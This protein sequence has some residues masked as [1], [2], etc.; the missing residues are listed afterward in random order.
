MRR[1]LFLGFTL[2]TSAFLLTNCA[3][4]EWEPQPSDSTSS[5]N[6]TVPPGTEKNVPFEV[7]AHVAATK[8]ASD[9]EN[10]AWSASDAVN[11][12]YAVSG[13]TE[14]KDTGSAE[15]DK[16]DTFKGTLATGIKDGYSYDWFLFY[17]YTEGL[18]VSGN[19][20][21]IT[22]GAPAGNTQTQAGYGSRAHIGGD[23]LPM[24]GYA[25]G[26][27]SDDIPS[28]QMQHLASVV[29][30]DVS[31]GATPPLTVTEIILT[32]S[33][34]II[35]TYVVD[36][37]S[38]KPEYKAVSG[39]KSA[40]LT[41][42]D[43][44]ELAKHETASFYIVVKPFT[45]IPSSEIRISV[46]GY[47]KKVN[48]SET[49]EFKAGESGTL[50]FVYDDI[51]FKES[52][53]GSYSIAGLW[54][55]GGTGLDY[56]GGGFV[57]MHNKEKLFD[58][59]GG[60]GV[61]AEMDNYLEFTFIDLIDEGRKTT[62]KCYNW[63]GEDGKN[64]SC[65]YKQSEVPWNQADLTHFYRQIP[66]GES[67]WTRD[68]SVEPNTVTFT[69]SE[70]KETVLELLAPQTANGHAFENQT[71]HTALNGTD[72]W[73][74]IYNDID[75][76]YYK[77]RD[78]YI[79]II[80]V[81]SVPEASRTEEGPFVPTLPPDPSVVPE[82]IAGTYSYS[83]A[84]CFGGMDPAFV[85]FTEKSWAFNDSVWNM[86]DDVYV[87]TA[88]GTDADGN[89]TG[90][91]D[92]QPGEGGTYWDLTYPADKHNKDGLGDLDLSPFYGKIAQ[93]K[94]QYIYNKTDCTVTF[95]SGDRTETANFLVPGSHDFSGKSHEVI[96]TFALDFNLN[97]TEPN[98]PGY[99]QD[100]SDFERFYVAPQNFVLH[101]Q[102]AE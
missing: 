68:Y 52:L 89:E 19:S 82:S 26:V 31:N 8:T 51:D 2:A 73:N 17:P 4:Q 97:Y 74:A 50:E 80:K 67:T 91:V 69:D 24:Y 64:W 77:P 34:D 37:S 76:V 28:A 32:A 22:I 93:G 41:V 71:F 35:G 21:E 96:A 83:N 94:S 49:V 30:I 62:G 27:P 72:N 33:E 57:D 10:L 85:G 78:Y 53:M 39:G 47:E 25:M 48:L 81:E 29:R 46:N 54:V 60:H 87:F 44:K 36:F 38:S 70:G 98:I 43:G 75:K 1:I 88:T 65:W 14:F 92:F 5:D 55:Y 12:W 56:G 13:A 20:A 59:E 58:D 16:D 42:T 102:K 100:W 11:V 40:R 15:Y 45:A 66:I 84:Y 79:E 86:Q 95:I 6:G 63:A 61:T 18:S 99:S 90:E 9:G 7:K 101:L 3:Y 23:A